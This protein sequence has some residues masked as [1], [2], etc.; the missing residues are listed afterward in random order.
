MRQRKKNSQKDRHI[1][2]ELERYEDSVRVLYMRERR[3]KKLQKERYPERQN[4]IKI[5]Y[6]VLY[7]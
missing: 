7:E 4:D 1:A 3:R 5:M 6:A 2:R